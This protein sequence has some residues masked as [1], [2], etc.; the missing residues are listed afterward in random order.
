MNKSKV[1]IGLN[2][3]KSPTNVGSVM[4]AAG[5][6]GVDKVLYTGERYDRAMQFNTDTKSVNQK[7]PL[8][9]VDSLMSNIPEA[10][11]LVCVKLAEGAIALTGYRHDRQ[12]AV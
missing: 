3:P 12:D 11:T 5:C 4:R 8:S 7:I 10:T 6:Y 2:N 1:I 9:G